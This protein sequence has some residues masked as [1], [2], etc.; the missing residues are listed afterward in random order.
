MNDIDLPDNIKSRILLFADDLKLIANAMNKDLVDEDLRSLERWEGL[1]Q[2]RFNLK[3]CKV[4]HIAAIDN[5]RNKYCLDGT[6]RQTIGTELLSTQSE[7]DLG[8]SMDEKFDFGENIKA[9]LAKANKMIVCV[10]RNVSCN[11]GNYL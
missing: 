1:W 11:Y 9:S 3:K 10:S 6:D 4:L 5:P 2:L 7:K 8:F